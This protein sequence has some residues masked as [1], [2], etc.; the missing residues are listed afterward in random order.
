[1][2]NVFIGLI[3]LFAVVGDIWL[4]QNNIFA[5]WVEGWRAAQRRP[6]GGTA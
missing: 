1:W 3:L 4:R 5:I 2:M 6:I